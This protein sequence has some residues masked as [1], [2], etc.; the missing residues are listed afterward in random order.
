MA[1]NIEGGALFWDSGINLDGMERDA[2]K[3]KNIIRDLSK[4]RVE[5]GG[6]ISVEKNEAA[7]I[8]ANAD[9]RLKDAKASEIAVKAKIQEAKLRGLNTKAAE[10]EAAALAK[11]NKETHEQYAKRV[12]AAG[13]TSSNKTEPIGNTSG[14]AV[15]DLEREQLAAQLAAQ[16][17]YNLNKAKQTVA[18]TSKQTKAV[19][20]DEAS[21]WLF[22]ERS[23]KASETE[24][25]NYKNQLAQ[26]QIDKKAAGKSTSDLVA[27]EQ[28]LKDKISDVN[29]TIALQKQ[30]MFSAAGSVD[31]LKARAAILTQQYN[32]LG[33]AGRKSA[34]GQEITAELKKTNQAL[35]ASGEQIEDHRRKVG[36]YSGGITKALSGAWGML[37]KLA[38]LIPGLGIAGIMG[39]LAEGIAALWEEF[40]K[41]NG[42]LDAFKAKL[43][44]TK[45][46]LEDGGY[47]Q[48]Q[49]AVSEMN[50]AVQ[51]A[52]EGKISEKE[53]VEQYN[54]TLGDSMGKV[55]GLTGVEKKMAD[56][57]PA[58][59]QMMYEKAA[60]A[61]AFN[62]ALEL[63]TKKE[64]VETADAGW[65]KRQ[66]YS[67]KAFWNASAEE[68]NKMA[69]STGADSKRAAQDMINR[70]K[71]DDKD[72]LD[73]QQKWYEEEMIKRS[74]KAAEIAKKYKLDYFNEKDTKGKKNKDSSADFR[75]QQEAFI[76][77]RNEIEQS[78][79]KF[80]FADG[81]E[82]EEQK[83][84]NYFNGL[85]EKIE[86]FNRNPNNKIKIGVQ[87]VQDNRSKALADAAYHQE[88]KDLIDELQIREKEYQDYEEFKKVVGEKTADEQYRELV[89]KHKTYLER[90]EAEEKQLYE[91][92]GLTALENARYRQIQEERLKSERELEGKRK[93]DLADW[94]KK[95]LNEYSNFAQQSALIEQERQQ[96][97]KNAQDTGNEKLIDGINFMYDEKQKSLKKNQADSIASMKEFTE[98]VIYTSRQAILVQIKTLEQ[99]LNTTTLPEPIRKEILDK[100]DELKKLSAMPES[101]TV[102]LQFEREIR[103]RIKLLEALAKSGTL[104]R[105]ELER[106]TNEINK[107]KEDKTNIELSTLY[108][109]LDSLSTLQ[110]P[111]TDLGDSLAELGEFNGNEIL[112][113]I[114]GFISGLASQIGNLRDTVKQIQ[115]INKER[116]TTGSVSTGTQVDAYIQGA[117]F[118]FNV[119]TSIIDA[120]K[121]RKQ[122]EED[123]YRSAMGLQHD[124]TLSLIEQQRLQA[125]L[126]ENIF[127]KDYFG[128]AKAGMEAAISA[129]QKYQE[130]IAKLNDGK[131][132]AGQRN[133]VDGKTLGSMVLSGAGT[134]AV[135][136]TAI[137]GWAAGIGT[138][139]GAVVGGL[140]GLVGGL[141]A[142]KKKEVFGGLLNEW[143]ELLKTGANGYKEIN[144]ELAQA[145]IKN[146][147]LDDKT[148]QL[149]QNVLDAK[150][151]YEA[152]YSQMADV[153]KDLA[154]NVGNDLRNALVEAWKA[155]EDSAKAFG[156]TVD[157]VLENILSNLLFHAAFNDL[158]DRLEKDL[159]EDFVNGGAAD[160][161][162]TLGNF[163]K[164]AE[165]R[166]PLW[167][168][169]LEAMNEMAQKYGLEMFKRTLEDP[170]KKN[171]NS[172]SGAYAQASQE[173]IDLL[174]S[175]SMGM[176]VAQLQSNVHLAS[177]E[178]LAMRGIVYAE[179]T[180]FNT[181]NTVARLD[182][183]ISK[184]NNNANNALAAG[185]K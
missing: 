95:T 122:A 29:K 135:I 111:L 179:Q 128:R 34:A 183:I 28:Q 119:V 21:G 100:I 57:A 15:S 106:T 94:T 9:A 64:E 45:A 6:G 26:L 54:K 24:L 84:K 141:F 180:A 93:K 167:E 90:L 154:G 117:Q 156:K 177:I 103:K 125:E 13:S 159:T 50:V 145:L 44:L 149:V 108:K 17:Y 138:V 92:G 67:V 144:V 151:A 38:Y 18:Q 30:E 81:L 150:D 73:K 42:V 132:K 86:K 91:K 80:S 131:A 22:H 185:I 184:M 153:V 39:L 20:D 140:V 105:E 104:T 60:A 76:A 72:V 97:I 162:D 182:V 82:S 152:A 5:A 37:R 69:F 56:N 139:I 115:A 143:P 47:K 166:L 165:K 3:A 173:S 55:T 71:K 10:R 40:K 112:S 59:I 101:K 160:I 46:A 61:A 161:T 27:G 127:L 87:D 31:Q 133:V 109:N 107:L 164:E 170:A 96:E 113:A 11:A 62:K 49:K 120:S 16:E 126:S 137:G 43:E 147:Q 176:R 41:G 116:A 19:I 12:I 33:E 124:Y 75:R 68:R 98:D 102:E 148:K 83:I 155:G 52:R 118:L 23:L 172:L 114:G 66:L 175:H 8:K 70:Q 65:W 171:K 1:T 158:F 53:A 168:A 14:S 110:Q 4:L 123:F 51:L 36:N 178:Q 35:I 146:N 48:A 32:S 163:Y 25:A 77:L 121:R 174:T 169:S 157:S 85:L 134:G 89:A 63:Q 142:K 129:A 2:A 130:A 58:F 136:G 99:I 7:I 88:T 79:S 74:A 78:G 181:G